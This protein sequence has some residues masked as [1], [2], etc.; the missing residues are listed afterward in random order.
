M[1]SE[2]HT[3]AIPTVLVAVQ[4]HSGAK[5]IDKATILRMGAQSAPLVHFKQA[6][7]SEKHA[8]VVHSYIHAYVSSR[9]RQHVEHWHCECLRWCGNCP[10]VN[11]MAAA[12]GGGEGDGIVQM[13]KV[14]DFEDADK[15]T[16]ISEDDERRFDP[17]EGYRDDAGKNLWCVVHKAKPTPRD[18][19]M[20]SLQ[21]YVEGGEA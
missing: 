11:P 16:D 10:R 21:D 18:T 14:E 1:R 20:F 19:S 13:M 9:P 6:A 2:I 7:R 5:V 8:V 4:Q 17:G 12:S 15:W 3:E